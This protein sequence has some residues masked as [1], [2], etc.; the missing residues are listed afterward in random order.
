MST[1]V[2][3]NIRNKK[4]RISILHTAVLFLVLSTLLLF[5]LVFRSYF[6]LLLIL[7][8]VVTI[9]YSL[10][11]AWKA[12]DH[13]EASA[14]AEKEVL[15]PDEEVRIIFSFTNRSYY[16]VMQSMWFLSAGNS[17]YRTS[18]GQK[19]MLAIPPGR[20][21]QFPLTI[22]ASDLG[23]IFFTCN[24][25]ILKDMFGAFAVHVD[26][27]VECSFFVLPRPDAP[28]QMSLPET[29][30]GVAELSES[31]RKGNDHSEVSDIRAYIAGD[32]PRDIHWKLSARQLDL[33]VKER[34]SLS[35]SEH[36]L[37][38]ELPAVKEAAEK[39]LTEGYQ[40]IKSLF[41]GH[42]TVRLLVWN[43]HLFSFESYSCADTQELDAAFCEIFRT[44]LFARSSDLLRQY[45]RNCYPQ[46]ASY[47][48]V[49]EKDGTVQLEI[50]VNG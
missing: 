10:F 1:D 47:M 21:K 4:I 44:E 25:Y 42:M 13:I 12:A 24:E 17:F 18:A 50:C 11:T 3:T 15:R 8:W 35:G 37:L 40:Q 19:L 16:S 9:P 36:I 43:G 32:R 38:L 6:F 49:T 39:L 27:A 41:D 46:L 14:S 45:M 7:A 5:F 33:M 31:T 30:S 26:C 23:R 20:Q 48:C 29:Y 22:K 28:E 34:V 2:N